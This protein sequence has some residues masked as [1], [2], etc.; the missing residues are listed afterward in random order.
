MNFVALA[1]MFNHQI[2]HQWKVQSALDP[3][4]PSAI[5]PH[6]LL[7]DITTCSF[8]CRASVR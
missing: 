6:D 5:G 4:S 2:N 3:Q 8:D 1:H 7:T